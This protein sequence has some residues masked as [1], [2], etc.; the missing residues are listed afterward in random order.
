[1][2]SEIQTADRFLDKA[3]EYSNRLWI[4]F[5][6]CFVQY[7]QT[8]FIMGGRFVVLLSSEGVRIADNE[9]MGE[10]PNTRNTC[11]KAHQC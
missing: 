7:L 11:R 6:A 4:L 10:N 1:M 3:F 5:Q 2:F 8:F 9:S